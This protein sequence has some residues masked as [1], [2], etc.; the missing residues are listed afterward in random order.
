MKSARSHF[1][2]HGA[3][4]LAVL[5]GIAGA[6]LA[7]R[8]PILRLRAEIALEQAVRFA[9]EHRSAHVPLASDA[10][11]IARWAAGWLLPPNS[12]LNAAVRASD[13]R[14]DDT[15]SAAH[16][17]AIAQLLAG[18]PL[19]AV[20]GLTE[21]PAS[22][23]NAA[24]WSNLAA[25]EIATAASGYVREHL[26]NALVDADHAS[27]LDAD[28]SAP[29][30]IRARALE[31]LNLRP[32]AAVAWRQYLRHDA[33][34]LWARIARTHAETLASFADD[35][36]A[37]RKATANIAKLSPEELTDLTRRYPQQ[38][39]T[40][41]EAVYLGEW[42]DT[43]EQD[44]YKAA[45]MSLRRITTIAD[46]L[47]FS[48]GE[49]LLAD[50]V[51]SIETAND[52]RVRRI[53]RAFIT[54]RKGRYASNEQNAGRAL[55][56][57]EEA[58]RLF[59]SL[60]D[61]MAAMSEC[62]AAIALIDLNRGAEARQRLTALVANERSSGKRHRALLAF[63]LY[64]IALSDASEGSWTDSLA[65]AEE[66]LSIFTRLG[67][68]GLA[69]TVEALISQCYD[70][71][72]QRHLAFQYGTD[73]IASLAAAGD[74]RRA[75]ITIGGLSRSALRH[76]DWESARVLIKA[77]QLTAHTSVL[78]D[79]CD[80]F[81][82]LAAAE[83]HLGHETEWQRA[84]SSARSAAVKTRDRA[85]RQKLTADT[86]AVAG[87]LMRRKDPRSA[88]ALLS[89]AV[90]FQEQTDRALLL[91]E[92]YLQRGRANIDLGRL[93]EAGADFESGIEQLEQQ[94]TR[95]NSTELRS[96]IFD[97]AAEL[98]ASAVSLSIARRDAVRAF[99]Y[100]ERG[101]ARAITEEIAARDQQI[102]LSPISVERVIEILP[103]DALILE[104]EIVDDGVVILT[105]ARD[106]L[107]AARIPVSRAVIEREVRTFVEAL[108]QTG[109]A[110]MIEDA[111]A[112]LFGRLVAPIRRRIDRARTLIVVPDA[113]LQ[114]LPFAALF[115]PSTRR[116]LVEDHVLLAAPSA[117]LFTT[118][119]RRAA[120]SEQAQGAPTALLLANPLL[121]GGAFADLSP[122]P[123]SEQEARKA[124]RTYSRAAVLTRSAV[125]VQRFASAA[126]AYD[127]VYF[128]GHT[129]IRPAEPWHSALLL[130]P[131][132]GDGGLL[133]VQ[134]IGRLVF[135]R[136]RTVILA[137]CSTLQGHRSGVE[138]VPSVARAFLVAGVPSVVGTLW[139][140]DDGE[141]GTLVDA[142]HQQLARGVPAPDALRTSQL[143]AIHSPTAELRHPSRWSVF[144]VL[145]TREAFHP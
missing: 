112:R 86:H 133:T 136:T 24:V 90:S 30:F 140:V 88:I 37:W 3:V 74:S 45:T 123:G 77:E 114:Q 75:R 126:D 9:N 46:T 20:R 104:Y 42:A 100:V 29:R 94:R 6:G 52:K 41:A 67:E 59:S 70:F 82:R 10:G 64:H 119:V 55:P 35:A 60:S 1:R 5:A 111:S 138:G 31:S 92:L 32:A 143:Q 57:Y 21:I 128:A 49:F 62:Y 122:L 115:D 63:A 137:S 34:S 14:G 2:T 131:S 84:L 98:F 79:D 102:P 105:L 117:S 13:W 101:R 107:E 39:R 53:A 83:Y 17:A 44:N 58:Q 80:T 28:A 103:P 48:S 8:R 127:I 72:G 66:S 25:S 129:V 71:L 26:L 50:V 93:D 23:R 16:S 139:D 38:A 43:V 130:A 108:R 18:N 144:A 27:S 95:V 76:G 78:R 113:G 68:R 125:T 81:L 73:A 142:L 33:S 89:A 118:G 135:R 96:G 120:Q 15:E 54:Y 36:A 61:P 7:L 106:G 141:T 91:P 12:P 40:F 97:D 19:E 87:S 99:G 4:W 11:T 121:E 85:L 145:A 51:A 56:Y 132:R 134:Q 22:R 109:N 116:F 124:M 65:A 69:G 47:R 110:K